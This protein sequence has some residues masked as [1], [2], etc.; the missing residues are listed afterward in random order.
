[1]IR[2]TPLI[3]TDEPWGIREESSHQQCRGIV[4]LRTCKTVQVSEGRGRLDR[5]RD[6]IQRRWVDL[7]PGNSARLSYLTVSTSDV[8]NLRSEEDDNTE[9]RCLQ[10][11]EAYVQGADLSKMKVRCFEN[12]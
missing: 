10:A 9:M 4:L 6:T 11:A 12:C 5:Q 2:H 3:A 7:R 1:M 8:P